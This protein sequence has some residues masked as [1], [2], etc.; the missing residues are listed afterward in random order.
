MRIINEEKATSRLETVQRE[1]RNL[2]NRIEAL[3]AEERD[4]EIFLRVSADYQMAG[5]LGTFA[6]AVAQREE[7]QPLPASDRGALRHHEHDTLKREPGTR[8]TRIAQEVLKTYKPGDVLTAGT[9]ALALKGKFKHPAGKIQ[10]SHYLSSYLNKEAQCVNGILERTHRVR[11]E[12][13][14][15]PNADELVPQ[16]C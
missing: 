3:Q 16:D 2:Q 8:Q 9:L 5:P 14:I 1:I 4:L 15:K 11:G 6:E 12:Y 7:G 10:D 13:R